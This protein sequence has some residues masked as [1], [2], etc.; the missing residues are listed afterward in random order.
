MFVTKKGMVMANVFV[1]VKH[2]RDFLNDTS[3]VNSMF[4][5]I[6]NFNLFK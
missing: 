4:V 5:S 2:K 6:E 1:N 3:A